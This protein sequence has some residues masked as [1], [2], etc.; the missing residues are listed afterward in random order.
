MWCP[1]EKLQ[2]NVAWLA[3]LLAVVAGDRPA[4]GDGALRLTLPDAVG[5]ALQRGVDAKIARLEADRAEAALGEARSVYWPQAEVGSLAGWSD[6]QSDTINAIDGQGVLRRYP[7][8]SLGG[9]ASWLSVTIDQILFDLS[10]WRGVE[11]TALEHDVAEVKVTQQREDVALA[12]TER[13]LTLLRVERLAAAD[14]REVA[15]AEWLDRQ[16]GMLLEAGRA[17]ASEREQAALALEDARTKAAERPIEAEQASM[18]LYQAIGGE[19]DGPQLFVLAPESLPAAVAPDDLLS[20]AVLRS[21]PELRV[22]ELRRR[23]EEASLAAARAEYLPKLSLR[24]G[25]F[26]Y[27]VKRY[28]SFESEMA[29]GVDLHMPVFSGFKTMS[30]VEGASAALEEARTRYE[31]MHNQKRARLKELSARLGATRN[32]PELAERRARLADERLRLADLSL[33]AGRGTLGEALAARAEADRARRAAVDASL[34]RVL[35]WARMEHDRGGLAN[36]L[37][38]KDDPAAP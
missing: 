28:D 24:G 27:G 38:G 3:L 37:V 18:A 32:Q 13:Y 11:R 21:T 7:L 9:N 8:S 15:E 35:L 33:Q 12:V 23:M 31:A 5:Q 10:R 29:V 19:A 26:H 14:Q 25:Y 6:R 20:D 22:L 36:A 1:Q 16:A 34:D 4:H 17:L 30:S 2:R